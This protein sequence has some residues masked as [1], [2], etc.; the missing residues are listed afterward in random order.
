MTQETT[1]PQNQTRP[2][3]IINQ[4]EKSNGIGTAGFVL[5]L[6]ALFLG[7]VPFLGWIIWMLG[8]IFSAVGVF[9][10]PKGLAIAG[11]VISLIGIVL[12]IVVFGAILGAAA[13]F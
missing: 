5:A 8:L 6:I 11:L 3:V 12:L 9:R 7:W 13:L 4:A 10:E 1:N 2:T